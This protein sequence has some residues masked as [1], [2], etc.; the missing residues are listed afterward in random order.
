[1]KI[2][3]LRPAAGT[4]AQAAPPADQRWRVWRLFSAPHRL[5]FF[6]AA[7]LL[8]VS[9]A[10]W[11]LVLFSRPLGVALPWAVPPSAAHG[12]LMALG[13]M[14]L[15]I[16]GFLFTAGPRWLGLPDVPATR[17]RGPVGL[18]VGGWLLVL[19]GFHF[20][21]WVA[22]FGMAAVALGWSLLVHRFARLLTTSRAVDRL[23]ATLITVAAAI[24]A[25]ALWLAAGA[26]A[27]G[28]VNGQRAAVQIAL[29]GFLSPLFASVS[30]RMI[31]FFTTSAVPALDAWRPNWLL[32]VMV[33]VLW[34]ELPF[35]LGHLWW[36]LP[37]A[38]RWLQV[39]VEVP[40]AVLLLWLAWR[41]GLVQSLKIRLLAMLHAGFLWLGVALAL[42][43]LSHALM[44][45]SNGEWSLGLAPTHA[46]TMG[47]LG[48][49]MIAM[50]TRVAA[51]HSG[52][53]L[54][55][56]DLAWALYWTLQ[57]A[58]VLRV[59]AAL[60]PSAATALTLAA[61]ASWSVA[62]MGWAWRYGGWLGRP[63]IDG[64]PG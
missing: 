12:L 52:R 60:W 64:R 33:G 22:A 23:H 36:S 48:A 50:T 29:W 20:S 5:G 17:L 40:A 16:T 24:G 53:P 2:V 13:A 47:Y 19:P 18:M 4:G 59:G 49:T 6:A 46:L 27:A 8:A 41:W 63:R 14:P 61:V 26:L 1:V 30:H 10:W 34:L 38:A 7:L 3:P 58:A 43:A 56:D 45:S 39:A 54:A 42:S 57:A 62:A 11:A 44:A 32:W 51:G 25:L 35:A 55:A 15:F 21:T 31:P 9:A 28:D 37:A